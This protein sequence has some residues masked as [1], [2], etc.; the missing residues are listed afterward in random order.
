M[1]I[2]S[3]D[4]LYQDACEVPSLK[5]ARGS[6]CVLC[7]EVHKAEHRLSASLKLPASTDFLFTS[8]GDFLALPDIS[9]IREGHVLLIPRVHEKSFVALAPT[10]ALDR[11]VQKIGDFLETTY[12]KDV[13]V[14]E[15]GS[16]SEGVVGSCCVEHAHLHLLP[17]GRG[18]QSIISYLEATFPKRTHFMQVSGLGACNRK[19]SYMFFGSKAAGYQHFTCEGPVPSQFMRR[20]F[21]QVL[22][23]QTVSDWKLGFS[24]DNRQRAEQRIDDLMTR[25]EANFGKNNGKG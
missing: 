7:D 6:E 14:F 8:D 19:D 18:F 10:A 4:I 11:F 22:D 17:L 13:V 2:A 16:G 21:A 12:Q 9:P 23:D 5:A 25:L 15:H 1:A 24:A 20:I 3:D